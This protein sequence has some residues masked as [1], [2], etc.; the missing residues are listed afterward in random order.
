MGVVMRKDLSQWTALQEHFDSI[1]SRHLRDLFDKDPARAEDFR[2]EAAGWT[3]DYS[4]NR[5]S[6]ETMDL[7]RQLA[8]ACRVE[9][10]RDAM[11][12]GKHINGTEDRA[13][14]H[15]ALRNTSDEPVYADGKDVMPEVRAV[16]EQMAEFS[17]KIRQGK[18]LGHTGKP[19]KN[20]I[21]IGIGGSDLGPAMA[22]LALESYSQRDLRVRFVSNVDATALAENVRDLDPAETLFVIA[23][24]T[25][26]T[27]ET[28]TNARSARQGCWIL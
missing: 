2:L 23:S 27:Q 17:Q 28:L 12:A 20:V 1:H 18:W 25:F 15:V 8:K 10:S 21:N 11:F 26:T 24:K 4:K 3:L 16:L 13:V 9:Q 7:L 14:L 22:T 5:V 19:I 6:I